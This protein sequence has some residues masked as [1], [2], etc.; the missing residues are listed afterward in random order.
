M[1]ITL[2]QPLSIWKT[3]HIL[4]IPKDEDGTPFINRLRAIESFDAEI[5]LL[6]R[7]LVSHRTMNQ[8][9]QR[10]IITDHQWGGR[11]NRQCSDL[12][13][14][15]E[16]HATLHSLTRYDGAVTDV[17]ATNC[18]DHIPPSIMYMAYCKAGLHPKPMTLL[19]KALLS[20]KYIPIT[21]HGESSNINNHSTENRLFGPRQGS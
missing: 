7:I 21:E 2:R 5:N 10:G 1:A 16:L 4:L 13:L 6:R 20:H 12:S 14:Q 9:E 17:D 19:S 8:A 15:K 11:R 18:F 3:V